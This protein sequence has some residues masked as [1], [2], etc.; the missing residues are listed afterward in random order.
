MVKGK[1]FFDNFLDG[2]Y[3]VWAN[4]P[5]ANA[6]ITLPSPLSGVPLSLHCLGFDKLTHH[7]NGNG[8]QATLPPLQSGVGVLA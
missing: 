7:G 2:N 4:M 5:F 6:L 3:C 1:I 8:L